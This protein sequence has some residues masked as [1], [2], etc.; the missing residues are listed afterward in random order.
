MTAGIAFWGS[1][2]A[3]FIG[4]RAVAILSSSN[5]L[6]TRC[7]NDS[8]TIYFLRPVLLLIGSNI[9]WRGMDIYASKRRHRF[10]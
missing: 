7:P 9:H 8:G 2:K 4:E 10:W 6:H 3:P 1:V 5:H